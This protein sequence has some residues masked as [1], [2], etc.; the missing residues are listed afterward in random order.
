MQNLRKLLKQKLL[1]TNRLAVLGI[2][3]ELRGDDFAGFLVIQ[4][5]DQLLKNTPSRIPV[6][7]F[8]GE[9]APENLTGEI[10]KFEPSDFIIV[11]CADIGKKPGEAALID[12]NQETSGTSFT[13]HRLPIAIMIHY[14]QQSFK[15]RSLIIGI[16]PE[17]LEICKSPSQKVRKAAKEVAALLFELTSGKIEKSKNQQMKNLSS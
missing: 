10:K 7:T 4:E 12:P 17:H 16:Q 3:S 9:T 1:K 15:C 14:F 5:L 13:T 2:G 8:W 6:S 11:D